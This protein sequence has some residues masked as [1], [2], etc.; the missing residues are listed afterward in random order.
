M[1][2]IANAF[3]LNMVAESSGSLSWKRVPLA[4]AQAAADGRESIV[5]HPDTAQVFATQLN[6]DVPCNRVN[7]SLKPG[8][9]L[10]VGQYRG[11]RL[12]EGATALPAGATIEWLLVEIS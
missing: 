12:P 11:P 8:D 9:T 2:Y 7:V 5:G 10:L 1:H 4:E 6:R 3:S